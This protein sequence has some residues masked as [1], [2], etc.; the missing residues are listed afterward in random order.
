[1]RFE[2]FEVRNGPRLHVYLSAHPD[3]ESSSQVSSGGYVDL[4]R[5]K[6]NKGNQ[7]YEIPESANQSELNSVM[8]YCVP[9]RVTPQ[10]ANSDLIVSYKTATE[11]IGDLTITGF[12]TNCNSLKNQIKETGLSSP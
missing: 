6:G 11:A 1:M 7:N 8:I 3:P 10:I 5:I 4:G 9:F 12:L 2:D